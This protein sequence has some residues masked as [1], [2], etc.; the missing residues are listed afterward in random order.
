MRR[1][2]RAE[3]VS[4]LSQRLDAEFAL[5]HANGFHAAVATPS[6][7]GCGTF[8]RSTRQS[9]SRLRRKETRRMAQRKLADHGDVGC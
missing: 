8:A 2:C 1:R 6:M 7:N 4:G 5:I 9:Q 3:F